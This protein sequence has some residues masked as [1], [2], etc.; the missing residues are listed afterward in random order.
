MTFYT[1]PITQ[2]SPGDPG[3]PAQAGNEIALNVVL[4]DLIPRA[5]AQRPG[6]E[7]FSCVLDTGASYSVVKRDVAKAYNLNYETDAQI[8]LPQLDFPHAQPPLRL[9]NVPAVVD[10]S[11]PP[12]DDIILGGI[13]LDHFRTV[14]LNFGTDVGE[15]DPEMKRKGYTIPGVSGVIRLIP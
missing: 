5:V 13:V 10:N 1:T 11:F 2:L 7:S 14:V 12:S 9:L 4:V 15:E 6:G 3:I 8:V